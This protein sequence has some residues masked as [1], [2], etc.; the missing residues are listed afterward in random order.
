MT[1]R[2]RVAHGRHSKP[3]ESAPSRDPS[4]S[5]RPRCGHRTAQGAGVIPEEDPRRPKII[6]IGAPQIAVRPTTRKR[7]GGTVAHGRMD[8][9]QPPTQAPSSVLEVLTDPE[10][11][12]D[13]SPIDFESRRPRRPD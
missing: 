2:R 7:P 1:R 5:R 10:A 8:R 11:I 13:W 4:Y 6:R 3:R 12:R 9:R